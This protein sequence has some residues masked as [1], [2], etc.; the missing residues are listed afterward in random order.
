M[1]DNFQNTT[2]PARAAKPSRD[3]SKPATETPSGAAEPEGWGTIDFSSAHVDLPPPGEYQGLIAAVRLT[4]KGDTLW[5][6]VTFRL[7][8]HLAMPAAEMGAIAARDDSPHRAKVADGY[9]L[10]HRLAKAAC[11]DLARITDPFDLPD[12]LPAALF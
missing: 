4:D 10:L 11:F 3:G 5:I 8:G 12:A 9:R 7:D 1:P 6:A 2:K